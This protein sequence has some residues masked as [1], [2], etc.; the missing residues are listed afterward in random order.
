[1][2]RIAFGGSA[3]LVRPYESRS[4]IHAKGAWLDPNP[5]ISAYLSRADLAGPLKIVDARYRFCRRRD[6]KSVWL[7]SEIDIRTTQRTHQFFG[8][9]YSS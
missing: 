7:V 1:M 4:V 3:D 2:I 6:Y 9:G 8:F 5:A